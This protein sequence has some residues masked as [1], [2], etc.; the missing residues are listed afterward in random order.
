MTNI[1][2]GSVKHYRGST[3]E[4]SC[5]TRNRILLSW[6]LK[7]SRPLIC[8]LKDHPP[9]PHD[10]Q[11]PYDF[12]L[13]SWNIWRRTS[14]IGTGS[15]DLVQLDGQRTEYDRRMQTPPTCG[16]RGGSKGRGRWGICTWTW[17]WGAFEEGEKW[18]LHN[19]NE[20]EIR[21][22]NNVCQRLFDRIKLPPYATKRN[23]FKVHSALCPQDHQRHR[24]TIFL[25]C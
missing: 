17:T 22:D 10:G 15:T 11:V 4:W 3:H 5:F 19:K 16:S 13:G 9:L 8:F 1:C 23:P 2:S 7:C 18:I 6:G 14:W 25:T 20:H 21:C 24:Q 12:D